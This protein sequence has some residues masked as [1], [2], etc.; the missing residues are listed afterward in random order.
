MARTDGSGRIPF[1]LRFFC[2]VC[3]PKLPVIHLMYRMVILIRSYNELLY[4]HRV[5]IYDPVH[6]SFFHIEAWHRRQYQCIIHY[7]SVLTLE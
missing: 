5:E 6:M 1:P 7:I 2:T 3:G 4:M